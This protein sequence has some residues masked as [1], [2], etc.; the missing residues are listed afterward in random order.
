[1]IASATYIVNWKFVYER[2]HCRQ[3]SNNK[4]ENKGCLPHQY[5]EGYLVYVTDKDV[6]QKLKSKSGPF[7]IV[8]GYPDGTV[9]IQRSASVIKW[10]NIRRLH[11]VF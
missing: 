10:I 3:L 8:T 1:M 7:K 2:H 9:S 4:E 5:E 11:P 6:K